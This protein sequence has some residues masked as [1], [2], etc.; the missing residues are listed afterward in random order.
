[1]PLRSQLFA[2]DRALEACL[3]RDDAHLTSGTQGEH[4]RLVQR[5]LVWFGDK[6]ITASEYINGV[7]GPTTATS[8]LAYKR[9][10]RIINFSYQSQE[11]NIVGK[12]TIKAM[13]DELLRT[14]DIPRHAQQ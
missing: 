2:G 1:V 13:D 14:Q 8:V 11:D 9:A 10:R 12:M 4:V 3:T 7:Y 6:S 5:A